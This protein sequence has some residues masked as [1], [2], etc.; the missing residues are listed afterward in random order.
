MRRK[1]PKFHRILGRFYVGS[2]MLAAP[3]GIVIVIVAPTDPFFRTGVCVHATLWFITTLM[4]FL[5]ARNRHILQHKQWMVRSYIL[6][7]SFITARV[8]SPIWAAFGI[9]PHEYGIVDV[10]LNLSYLLVADIALNWRE[11]TKPAR[12]RT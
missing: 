1:Y 4:A 2:I 12:A 3:L 6:T 11:L 8:L 7:F 5:T 9:T 10:I